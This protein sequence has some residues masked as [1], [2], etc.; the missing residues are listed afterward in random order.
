VRLAPGR[1]CCL[2]LFPKTQN[3]LLRIGAIEAIGAIDA[4]EQRSNRSNGEEAHG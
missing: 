2:R 1:F 3:V 4:T